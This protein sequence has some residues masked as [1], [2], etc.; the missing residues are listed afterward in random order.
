MMAAKLFLFDSEFADSAKKVAPEIAKI[1][2]IEL[3]QQKGVNALDVLAKEIGQYKELDELVLYFH[4]IPGGIIIGATG[5][6]LSDAAISKAFANTKTKIEHIRFEGC[7]VGEAPDEMA[8]FGRLFSAQD[9]SG[10]TWS[11]WTGNITVDIP[12]GTTEKAVKD[13]LKLYEMWL[14]T[15]SLSI[16]KRLVSQARHRTIKQELLL[17]WYQ[18]SL[19]E[20]PPYQNDNYKKSG[21]RTYK[22]R[23]EATKRTVQAK[24]AK[25]SDSPSPPFEYVTVKLR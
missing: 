15:D 6:G 7:H 25:R 1:W 3:K 22:R 18:Y 13:V 2:N 21:A 9:V 17:Q 5:Y 23:S 14:M 4:G 11:S 16:I 20:Y 12:R 8:A 19:E 24:D 10:Y